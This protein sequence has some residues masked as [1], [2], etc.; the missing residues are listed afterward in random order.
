[1]RKQSRVTCCEC[2]KFLLLLYPSVPD[3]YVQR[4][5]ERRHRWQASRIVDLAEGRFPAREPEARADPS[6]NARSET[7]PPPRSKPEDPAVVAALRA[8]TGKRN[9]SRLCQATA[10]RL[11]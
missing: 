8:V 10:E 7:P 3:W 6:R 4:A 1:M 9:G 11:F 5:M 2:R